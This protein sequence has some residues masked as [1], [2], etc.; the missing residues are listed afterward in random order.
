MSRVVTLSLATR[1]TVH[2]VCS[3]R[4]PKGETMAPLFHPCYTQKPS[5]VGAIVHPGW[6]RQAGDTRHGCQR[7]AKH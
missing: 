5:H 7:S 4:N 3:Q 1:P 2:P 6:Q